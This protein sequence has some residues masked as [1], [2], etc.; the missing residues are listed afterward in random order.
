MK[1]FF[2]FFLTTLAFASAMKVY[3]VTLN[4]KVD[5]NRWLD[6]QRALYEDAFD[7]LKS[8]VI[9]IKKYTLRVNFSRSLR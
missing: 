3:P 9:E 1:I 4:A 5:V 7:T 8:T 2:L 6:Q